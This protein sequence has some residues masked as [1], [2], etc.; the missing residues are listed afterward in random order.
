[1]TSDSKKNLELQKIAFT[2]AQVSKYMDEKILGNQNDQ[3]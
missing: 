3:K 1:M 2:V